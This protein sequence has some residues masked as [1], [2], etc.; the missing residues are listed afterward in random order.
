GRTGNT[1]GLGLEN[2]GLKAN[3]R[4]QLD[5]DDAYRTKLPH[6]YAVGDVIGYPSL[7]SAAYTQ[8]RAAG[9][10]ILGDSCAKLLGKD[11]PTGIYTSPE[12]SSIGPT[13]K[14]LTEQ[15]IP[16]EV[17]HSPFNTLDL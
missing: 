14:E 5:V 11:I 16:Y 7:A 12:I 13:E 15:G 17:G 6:V 10:H 9:L 4:G 2:V 1:D 3:S 8:G